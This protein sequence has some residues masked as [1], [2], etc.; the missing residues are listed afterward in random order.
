MTISYIKIQAYNVVDA[1]FDKKG[2]SF[3]WFVLFPCAEDLFNNC[4][5]ICPS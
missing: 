1:K 2:K 5:G 4:A 3:K